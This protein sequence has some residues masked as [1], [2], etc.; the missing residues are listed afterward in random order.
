MLTTPAAFARLAPAASYLGLTETALRVELQRGKTLADVAHECGK[1]LDG[2]LRA[3]VSTIEQALAEAVA[4]GRL[5]PAQADA[6][7]ADVEQRMGSLVGQRVTYFNRG[8]FGVPSGD[9]G[10]SSLDS[11]A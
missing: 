6:I 7:V 5:A 8:F 3:L 2:L 1:P 4:H 10:L 9:A 11:A